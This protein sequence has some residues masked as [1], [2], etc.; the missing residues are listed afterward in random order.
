MNKLAHTAQRS[1]PTLHSVKTDDGMVFASGKNLST[2]EKPWKIH[3][4]IRLISAGRETDCWGFTE[5]MSEKFLLPAEW[6][7]VRVLV[8]N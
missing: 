4:V 6:R 8:N 3:G 1:H 2:A 5:S 7:K